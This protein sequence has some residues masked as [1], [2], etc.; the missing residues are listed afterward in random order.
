MPDVG[1]IE[2]S[3]LFFVSVAAEVFTFESDMVFSFPVSTLS[4]FTGNTGIHVT[5]H[6]VEAFFLET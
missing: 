4:D 6:V 3:V 5:H 1:T 2:P